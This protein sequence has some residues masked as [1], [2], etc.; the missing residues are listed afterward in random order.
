MS[1]RIILLLF[2]PLFWSNVVVS[3]SDTLKSFTE[4]KAYEK[5]QKID[6]SPY[7]FSFKKELPFLITGVGLASTGIILKYTNNTPPFTQEDLDALDRNDINSFDRDA[8]YN[9]NTK[10]LTAS[11]ILLIT[12]VLVPS[13]LLLNK[14]PRADFGHIMV[15]GLEIAFINYGLTAMSKNIFNRT[16]PY[17]YNTDL[18]FE[19]RSDSQSR[20]SFFSGHTSTTAAFTFFFA[21]VL[22]DYNPNMKV[23]WKVTLWTLTATFPA[24]T[25]YFRVQS[26]M[27]FKTDVFTGYIFGALTGW[28][29]PQLHKKKKMTPNLT[30]YPTRVF[31]NN[32]IGLTLKF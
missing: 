30:M 32:G 4:I 19:Q 22:N 26:G 1:S 2:I 10:A 14:N 23:V 24:A 18:S 13:F 7:D 3:Q 15:M 20:V 29:I 28:L 31:G 9:W 8:T 25:G 12:S 17:P 11:D 16:R 27:H 21:K 6:N 5:Q